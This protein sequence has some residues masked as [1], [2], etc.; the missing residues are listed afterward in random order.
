MQRERAESRQAEIDA[1]KESK[2]DEIRKTV[3]EGSDEEVNALVNRVLS[4]LSVAIS[5]VFLGC[6]SAPQT[7]VIYVPTDRRIE[8]CTNSIGIACKM[9]PNAVFSDLLEKAQELKDLRTEMAVDKR[10]GK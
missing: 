10:V 2:T 6:S 9:V 1:E 5:A 8:S 4:G 3:H 7:K